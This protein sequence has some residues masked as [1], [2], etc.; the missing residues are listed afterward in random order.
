MSLY[1]SLLPVPNQ[2][3]HVG[4]DRAATLQRQARILLGLGLGLG[5][6]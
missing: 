6:V 3:T 2:R 4:D 1:V 5:L